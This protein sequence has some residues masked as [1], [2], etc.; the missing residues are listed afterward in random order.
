MAK[1]T[2]I[3]G[4]NQPVVAESNSLPVSDL[5][6]ERAALHH[7]VKNLSSLIEVSIFV[8]SSLNLEHVLNLVM[9]KAQSVMAA[10]ASSVM[11]INEKTGMLEWE[12][13]LGEVGQQVKEK[14]QLKVGEGIAGW[15]AQSGQPLIVPDVSK[16][17][18]F[19]KKSD[20]TT[21]FTT[22]SILAAPLKVRNRIIGVAEVINPLHG[23]PFTEDDLDLFSTF[24]RQ[25]ALA[26]DNA[27]MHRA[28]LEKQKLDQQLE[29]ARTIQESFL[30]QK[31]P[32]DAKGRYSVAARSI[33]ATQIGGDF[34]DFIKIGRDHLGFVVGDVSG[35]G[36]PAALYMA[37][38]VS[39]FRLQ[40]Q[41]ERNPAAVLNKMNNILVE[42]GRRGM[43]VT[44]QYAMI[45]VATGR[46]S[47][48]TGGHPPIFWLRRHGQDG[49][50]VD[51][52][53]GA[54]LGI[55]HENRY[56]RKS[57]QLSPGD[58][59]VTFTDGV[60]EAKDREGFQYSMAR[61]RQSLLRPWSSPREL[62]ESVIKDVKQYTD[63]LP[64]HDDLTIAA[65][66]WGS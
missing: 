43:F 9:E 37:R 66:R 5:L 7:K 34:Y 29:S 31:F 21:G 63:G 56:E 4:S 59:L 55:L 20:V 16:D 27:R 40:S 62:I 35:K 22:R 1:R 3:S 6:A 58:Y 17:R 19:S 41:G 26:I 15:V 33:P 54:P 13:A 48:A 30:P 45:E 10:E 8:N 65:L 28:I 39:D 44:L 47:Y 11:L 50:F 2:T 60:V 51:K 46:V 23:K 42:R 25:V 24:S 64:R 14:I 61:L 32:R 38:L 36:V 52:G 53:G 18:R 12:I 57:L 49:D